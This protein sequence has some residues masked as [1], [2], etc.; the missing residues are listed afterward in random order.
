MLLALSSNKR[1]MFGVGLG[2]WALLGWTMQDAL[3][4][5]AK[6]ET[7]LVSVQVVEVCLA[8]VG[9]LD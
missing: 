9:L 4:P 6:D 2:A 3:F 7:P 1:I 8:M 5:P